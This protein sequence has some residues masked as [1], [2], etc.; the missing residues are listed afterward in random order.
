MHANNETGR[1]ATEARGDC[2]ELLCWVEHPLPHRRRPDFRQGGRRRSASD[3]LGLRLRSAGTRFMGR[4]G[5]AGPA[6]A[7]RDV[8]LTLRRE[9]S[10]AQKG[11]TSAAS[12]RPAPRVLNPLLFGGGQERGLRPGTLPV[13]LVVGLGKAAEARIPGNTIARRPRRRIRQSADSLAP[14][15]A[16]C[17]TRSTAIRPA[18]SRTS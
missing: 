18:R 6:A 3:R 15:S 10:S 1:T 13:P 2:R 7:G 12:G 14:T 4:K 5:S 9:G 8:L 17:R 16:T 11:A